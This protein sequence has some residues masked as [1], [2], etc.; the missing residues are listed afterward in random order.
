MAQAASFNFPSMLIAVVVRLA[1][2]VRTP[3]V[4]VGGV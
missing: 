2:I 3:V 4:D 1:R